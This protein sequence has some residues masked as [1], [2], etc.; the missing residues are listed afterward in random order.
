MI[1]TRRPFLDASANLGNNHKKDGQLD[2]LILVKFKF[3]VA[4]RKLI[5]LF[6]FSNTQSPRDKMLSREQTDSMI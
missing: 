6:G 2:A 3:N 4:I 1:R 5:L